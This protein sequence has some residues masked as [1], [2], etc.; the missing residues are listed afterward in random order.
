LYVVTFTIVHDGFRRMIA[1]VF[2]KA[3]PE[4]RGLLN[5]PQIAVGDVYQPAQS[6]VAFGR[7]SWRQ[8]DFADR[9]ILSLCTYHRLLI[10][11]PVGELPTSRQVVNAIKGKC[12][13]DGR[14][15]WP[16][17]DVTRVTCAVR[18]KVLFC[19]GEKQM[20]F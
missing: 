17:R 6:I 16:L 15:L 1:T 9:I 7:N 19:L 10:G 2:A 8:E 12:R 4:I 18:Q 11:N 14:S 5:T 3:D 13:R 20:T